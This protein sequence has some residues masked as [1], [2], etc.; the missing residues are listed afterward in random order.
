M[1]PKRRYLR[2]MS[3]AVPPDQRSRLRLIPA[4]VARC[5]GV[6]AHAV[7]TVFLAGLLVGSAPLGLL[8]N[9]T[10]TTGSSHHSG[11]GTEHNRPGQS[12]PGG[13]GACCIICPGSC[14]AGVGNTPYASALQTRIAVPLRIAAEGHRA[15]SILQPHRTHLLPFPNAPP[16]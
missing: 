4:Q 14:A 11:H 6:A 15:L 7:L 8:A 1:K 9:R 5:V 2:L 16:A 10:A 3:M 12:C 13:G